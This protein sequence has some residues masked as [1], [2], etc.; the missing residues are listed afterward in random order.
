MEKDNIRQQDPFSAYEKKKIVL[1]DGRVYTG[2]IL[3]LAHGKVELVVSLDKEDILEISP[4]DEESGGEAGRLRESGKEQLA[5]AV[6]DIFGGEERETGEDKEPEEEIRWYLHP[7]AEPETE[8]VKDPGREQGIQPENALSVVEAE[9]DGGEKP[10]GGIPLPD[11]PY[12]V[13]DEKHFPD[14]N[15]LACLREAF[16]P[17]D[18]GKIL[19]SSVTKISVRK[20]GILELTGIGWFGEL[21]TLD[22]AFN[23]I[24]E[25]DL[26]G[27]SRLERL[28][29][30][31]NELTRLD[32]S[33]NGKL[34]RLHC[35]A[36]R[37][38]VLDL[39]RNQSLEMVNCVKNQISSLDLS[40]TG[41]KESGVN[42]DSNVSLI[43]GM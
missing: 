12:V 23:G 34:K 38:T 28:N 27:N 9:A 30:A 31:N 25:L 42:A 32:I 43:T 40:G 22:C 13:L 33:R 20:K 11:D 36:N 10:A 18:E 26:G 4:L 1:K 17:G 3:R 2:N 5:R 41:L 21:V 29:C 14:Q 35:N 37:L 7:L 24:K 8:P 6:A 19:R 39:P 16:D 15:F